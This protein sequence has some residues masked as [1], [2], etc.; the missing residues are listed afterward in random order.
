MTQN[1]RSERKSKQNHI[2][3]EV[4]RLS[5]RIGAKAQQRWSQ[6]QQQQNNI[7]KMVKKSLDKFHFYLQTST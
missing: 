7:N 2:T 5:K 1:Y 4:A 6:Q 3:F